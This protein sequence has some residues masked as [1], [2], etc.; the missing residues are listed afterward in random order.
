MH[1]FLALVDGAKFGKRF[2]L[3]IE[4]EE[5]NKQFAGVN[6]AALGEGISRNNIAQ[7]GARAVNDAGTEAEFEFNR[8]F[9]ARGKDG[10]I[11][12]SSA[13]D[14]V[15]AIDVGL[16][17]GKFQRF[18]KGAKGFHLDLIAADDIDA[19]QQGNDGGHA[20]GSIRQV[21][22]SLGISVSQRANK[23]GKSQTR[24]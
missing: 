10:E 14:N 15:A 17:A 16:A 23:V 21:P 24:E 5:A 22:S 9:D 7:L 6:I 11:A 12:V 4:A 20:G 1:F 2:W 3:R 13:E 8:F 18:I 19:A